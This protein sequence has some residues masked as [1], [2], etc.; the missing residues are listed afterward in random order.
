MTINTV[1]TLVG[2]LNAMI[3]GSMLVLPVLG[4]DGG[5]LTIVIGC[6]LICA[7]T[8][9]TAFLL[10]HHLGKAKNVKYLILGHFGNDHTYTTLYNCF[11]WFSFL[12][13]MILYFN[14]FC[15]QI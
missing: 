6:V 2:L 5:Y 15:V 10:V 3:G 11:I 9:Y 14:L 4:M 7:V 1:T 12:S 8:G 13:A